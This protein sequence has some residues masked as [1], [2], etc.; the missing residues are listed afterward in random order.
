MSAWALDVLT[1]D[2]LVSGQ[3]GDASA[4]WAWSYFS[5]VE[6]DTPRP[7]EVTVSEARTSMSLRVSFL[8]P[9]DSNTM[10]YFPG[11]R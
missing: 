1:H 3:V 4:E 8:N 9:A 10:S 2:Y 7:L 6:K 11:F 5:M